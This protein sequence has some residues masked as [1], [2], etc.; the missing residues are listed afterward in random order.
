MRF[1]L[2]AIVL[3]FLVTGYAVADIAVIDKNEAVLGAELPFAVASSCIGLYNTSEGLAGHRSLPA[4]L[5]GLGVGS[6]S[7]LLSTAESAELSAL[8]AAMGVFAVMSSVLRFPRAES[9]LS[10]Q[11]SQGAPDS[12]DRRTLE[13][14]PGLRQARVRVCF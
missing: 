13:F 8:D 7:L 6:T 9:S 2:L 3:T 1:L 5:L 12:G 14:I 10:P 4:F 11:A